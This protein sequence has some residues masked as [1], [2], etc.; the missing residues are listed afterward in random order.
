MSEYKRLVPAQLSK[1]SREQQAA[2]QSSVH[3][4]IFTIFEIVVCAGGR[5][6]KRL[7]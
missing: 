6:Y 5:I 4:I 2:C 3:A 1:K 7:A